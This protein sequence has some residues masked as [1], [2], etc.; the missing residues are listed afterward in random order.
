MGPSL[1]R[2]D[3]QA[4]IRLLEK[5]KSDSKRTKHINTRFFFVHDRI[6][7]G[8]VILHYTPSELMVADFFTKPLQGNLFLRMRDKLL[9][10]AA[11]SE[12]CE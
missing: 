7:K 10:V 9:G 5:G 6:E 3:N 2:Q 8:E 1:V 11:F 12:G 4:T